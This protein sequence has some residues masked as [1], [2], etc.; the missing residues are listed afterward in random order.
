MHALCEYIHGCREVDNVLT[1]VMD[2]WLPVELE[3]EFACG[4]QKED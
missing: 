1:V 4:T 3:R 2:G